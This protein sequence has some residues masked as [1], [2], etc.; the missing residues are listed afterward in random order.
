MMFF[1][2]S[3]VNRLLSEH[4]KEFSYID[5]K[6]GCAAA[7]ASTIGPQR[8]PAS[9]YAGAGLYTGGLINGD[10]CHAERLARL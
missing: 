9:A 8:H 2:C 4:R 3:F 6:T 5:L 7:N 10:Q 1:I